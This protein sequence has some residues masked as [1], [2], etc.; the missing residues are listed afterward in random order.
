MGSRPGSFRMMGSWFACNGDTMTVMGVMAIPA[1]LERQFT[2]L[3]ERVAQSG[4]Y[5]DEIAEFTVARGE[6]PVIA[7]R[8]GVVADLGSLTTRESRNIVRKVRLADGRIAVLK[9]MGNRREPG[10]GEV[11]AAWTARGLPCVRPLDWGYGPANWVLTGY[12]PLRAM[13][14]GPDPA[15]RAA[16]AR[17][18]VRFIRAFHLSGAEVPRTR[19]WRDKLD[20]HLRW[21]LPLTRGQRLTEPADWEAKL[22]AAGGSTLLHGD[23]AGSNVLVAADG[24]FVLLDPPGAIRGPREADAGQIASHVGCAQ[25]GDP[26]D[27]AAEVIA[28]TDEAATAD[29]SLDPRLVA[30]FAGLNMLVWAGYFL[31]RHGHPATDAAGQEPVA[32]A[33][34]YL[35][36]SRCLVGRFRL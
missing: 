36:A 32:A 21:T 14:A 7:A 35:A 23:P 11:L 8:V 22:G 2:A 13:P 6:Y 26:A 9:V 1:D 4:L 24:S 5:R 10:E 27:K 15:T 20:A 29:P 30:L 34:S 18:L 33:E 17:G 16:D 31:A 12:L 25:A 3:R 28:L 19:T